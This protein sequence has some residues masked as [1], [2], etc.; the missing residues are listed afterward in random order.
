MRIHNIEVT[1]KHVRKG[2]RWQPNKCPLA[3]ALR[4][5]FAADVV[6]VGRTA[7]EWYDRENGPLTQHTFKISQGAAFQVQRFD[8]SDEFEPGIYQIFEVR[9]A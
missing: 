8:T 1:E 2:K 5:N 6:C 7:G 9:N 4:A 3:L